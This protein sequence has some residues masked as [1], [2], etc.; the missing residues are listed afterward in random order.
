MSSKKKAL[1]DQIMYLEHNNNVLQDTINQQ[2]NNFK[3]LQHDTYEN[4]DRKSFKV[5]YG[6]YQTDAVRL[7]DI[8]EE[9]LK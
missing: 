4:L 7:V 1:V 3:K 6:H 9:L 2:A 8:E 5:D